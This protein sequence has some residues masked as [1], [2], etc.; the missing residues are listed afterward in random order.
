MIIFRTD[1]SQKTGFGHLNRSSYLASLLK[2]KSEVL[3]CVE[4]DKRVT[5]FLDEKGFSYCTAKELLRRNASEYK[6]IVFD[7]RHFDE[8]DLRLL[9]H[10]RRERKSIVQI[11]D[12]GLSQQDT[13]YTIDSSVEKLFPYSQERLQCLLDGPDYAILHTRYRHFHRVKRKYKDKMKRILICFGGGADYSHLREGV[14]LLT[15]HGYEV[16]IAPG[17][18]LKINSP[19]TLRR[20]YKG[21]RFV[22]KTETLARA[23]FEADA[24]LITAGVAAFEAAAAGT[25]ALY[26]YYHNEQKCIAKAF[27]NKGAGLEIS[28]IDDLLKV[29]LIEKM[30]TLTLEKRIQ[31]GTN[32]KKLV[33]G[34]GVYR[35]IDFFEKNNII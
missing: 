25:P 21:I 8:E 30:K 22:G 26:L 35:I 12:L 23:F 15:R 16:K 32:G 17:F 4:K 19:K 14:D 5:R 2:S 11:T 29:D 7:L 28:N 24:A 6:S 18:Y 31:M 1:A 9:Q 20:I 27:E 3:F 34:R 10:G 33:D 13:D